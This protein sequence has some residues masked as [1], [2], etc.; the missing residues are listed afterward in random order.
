MPDIHDR[1][2]ERLRADVRDL[3]AMLAEVPGARLHR[4]A[5]GGWS[6]A[7]VFSHL[8]DSEQIY[9]VRL[10]LLLTRERAPL[11]AYDQDA[12]AARVGPFD[13]DAQLAFERWRALREN[14]LSIFESLSEEEWHRVGLHE[15]LGE[16][17]PV[18]IAE[19]L[20]E[21]VPGHIEQIHR[22]IS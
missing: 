21:H 7:M 12:L 22:A 5:A 8:A 14:N 15:E 11:T 2:L 20:A 13:D 3:A 18:W 10:R 4:S 16:V 9:G 1:T 17:T 19:T 6:P